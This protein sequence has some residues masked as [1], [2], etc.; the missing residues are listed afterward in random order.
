[1][2]FENEFE[3]LSNF[4]LCD[5]TLFGIKFTTPEHAYQASKTFCEAER[6]RISKLPT[7]GKAKRA[8]KKIELKGELRSDWE[9]VKI[10][11]M[12]EILKQKFSQQPFKDLLLNTGD[13]EIVEDN[14]WEDEFWGVC[15]GI[16]DNHLGKLLMKIRHEL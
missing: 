10:N 14:D 1:M 7:P 9:E 16:G 15:N 11:V 12:S 4:P 2:K 6:I 13:I 3:F 5:I 8:G